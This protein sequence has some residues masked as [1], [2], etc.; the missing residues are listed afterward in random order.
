[1]TEKADRRN[2]VVTVVGGTYIVRVHGS[3]VVTDVFD[4]E[5]TVSVHMTAEQAQALVDGVREAMEE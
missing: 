5:M 1:M 2:D 3:Y 4:G